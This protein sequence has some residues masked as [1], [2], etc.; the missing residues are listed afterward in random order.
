MQYYFFLSLFIFNCCLTAP[1]QVKY[2]LPI[3]PPIDISASFGEARPNH[4]HSGIDFATG[5]K[6]LP[7][8]CIADG[9]VERLRVGPGGYGYAIYVRHPDGNISVY[10]HLDRFMGTIA[11]KA[12]EI[13]RKNQFFEFDEY[14]ETPILPVK[15]GQIIAYTGNSGSSTGSHLHFEIRRPTFENVHN[16]LQFDFPISDKLKPVITAI[17]LVPYKQFGKVNGKS[18]SLRISLKN[19]V[20]FN[21]GI[22]PTVEGLVGIAYEGYDGITRSGSRSLAYKTQV[23]HED[24]L[25]F[26][27]AMDTF[28][29]ENSRCVNAF[30]DYEQ[31][32]KLS[33]KVYLCVEPSHHNSPIYKQTTN[34]GFIH[35]K[36]AGDHDLQLLLTDFSGNK[37]SVKFK[38]KS[39][40]LRIGSDAKASKGI[41][42]GQEEVLKF[43]GGSLFFAKNSLFDTTM[44]IIKKTGNIIDIGNPLIPINE[45]VVLNLEL[46]PIQAKWDTAKIVLKLQSGSTT[47]YLT[48]T[49]KDGFFKTKINLFGKMQLLQDTVAPG[50]IYQKPKNL[51]VGALPPATGK[52]RFKVND[53]MSGIH[54]YTAFLNG[55][56]TLLQF[57]GKSSI[58]WVEFDPLLAKGKHEL[59]VEV[60]DKVGNKTV[61]KQSFVK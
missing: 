37:N 45:A 57:D 5:G 44:I 60:A 42:P 49:V 58:M 40:A 24:S 22:T 6:N 34:K 50:V 10:A 36:E 1:A 52:A 32:K 2:I 3:E 12:K 27:K 30:L 53:S 11:E 21:K 9:Y 35:F 47:K 29:F 26:E 15:Q 19:G 38:V 25:I 43:D 28:G 48:G 39:Q 13:Q 20:L 59:I 18:Q 7:L 61:L 8:K 56:W 51:A 4:F 46:S 54:H 23:F 55:E 41:I 33:R 17:H 31:L 14:F 16:P